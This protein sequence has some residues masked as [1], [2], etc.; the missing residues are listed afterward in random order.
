MGAG[1]DR[2]VH[3]EGFGGNAAEGFG[4][5]GGG[6]DYKVAEGVNFPHVGLG[7]RKAD[8]CSG[9]AGE[10]FKGLQV[11]VLVVP[12][13]AGHDTDDVWILFLGDGQRSDK[14]IMPFPFGDAPDD[15]DNVS[16]V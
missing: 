3:G 12:D 13:A 8:V 4:F 10:S 6:R 7:T 2:G 14:Y 16:P 15:G 11:V 9:F 5:G 1:D